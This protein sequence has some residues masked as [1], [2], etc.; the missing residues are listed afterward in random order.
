MGV[1]RAVPFPW[2]VFEKHFEQYVN[3][4]A[5]H[6]DP[7]VWGAKHVVKAIRVSGADSA[8]DMQDMEVQQHYVNIAII[9][10]GSRVVVELEGAP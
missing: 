8:F 1:P 2:K 4:K 5:D 9:D 3:E 7:G 10:Q 6:P